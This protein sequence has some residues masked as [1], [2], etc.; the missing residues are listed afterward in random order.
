VVGANGAP[1]ISWLARAEHVGVNIYR[2]GVKLNSAPLTSAPYTDAAL[3]GTARALYEVRGVDGEGHESAAR[4]LPVLQAAFGLALNAA[5]GN[6]AMTRY[7]DV[8][9]IVVSN[10]TSDAACA[11][12][13]VTLTRS[14]AGATETLARSVAADLDVPA[15]G[16]GHL[17]VTL[18]CAAAGGAQSFTLRVAQALEDPCASV[19]YERAFALPAPL[20]PAVMIELSTT[21][22]PV[23][24][25]GCVYQAR[26]YNRCQEAI[27]LVM[28]RDATPG[29][30]TIQVKDAA[31]NVVNREDAM[32]PAA[33]LNHSDDGHRGFLTIPAGSYVTV[34]M[35]E[36]VI[37]EA[38]SA[39]SAASVEVTARQIYWHC[40]RADE[41]LSGP[42]TGRANITPT[43]T[44]Y[45][46]LG[47]PE[48][49]VYLAG[50]TL[51][52][53]GYAFARVD[54]ARVANAPVHAGVALG[55]S[56][57]FVDA[58]TDAE[59]AFRAEWPIAPGV[60]GLFDVW[61]AHPLVKDRLNQ[62]QTA[63]HQVYFR[64]G[65]AD[66]RT[67]AN[68]ILTVSLNVYN[69]GVFVYSNLASRFHAWSVDGTN[70]TPLASTVATGWVEQAAS[71]VLGAARQ[72]PVTLN[73]AS[74]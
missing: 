64:P 51:V 57:W 62:G 59:G 14:I 65:A 8:A 16:V 33:A 41:Q 60:S 43:P 45:T 67:A 30:L 18:S 39:A 19:I 17:A 1:V 55:D 61:A 5:S 22:Q 48:R 11:V 58:T 73:L 10:L 37:P 47:L 2:N 54:G 42:L 32:L 27:D 12:A 50:E 26:V 21:N 44:P 34:A 20:P 66:L 56:I 31:G 25:A 6:A 40:G 74:T 49:P 71:L 63:I 3:S 9:D 15:R 36:I 4:V 28:W 24:G 46:A 72:T 29:D 53:T 38:L 68:D 7:F 52:V 70:E 35:P 13:G 69:P 23:A